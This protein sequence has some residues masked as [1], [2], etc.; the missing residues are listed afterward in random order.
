MR[1]CRIADV[2]RHHHRTTEFLE[3]VSKAAGFFTQG[4]FIGCSLFEGRLFKSQISMKLKLFTQLLSQTH[5]FIFSNALPTNL[6]YSTWS[7]SYIP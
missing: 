6:L 1:A 2:P 3:L 4:D 7:S 5:F